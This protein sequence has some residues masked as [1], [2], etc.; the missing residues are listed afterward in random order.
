MT[1]RDALANSFNIPAVK[2]LQFAGVDATIKT[3]HDLGIKGLN[4]GSGWYGLSMTLGGGE[5]TLLDMTNAYST[6]A[7]YGNEV[8]ANPILQIADSQGQ[9]Y[10]TSIP[11]HLR[12]RWLT[13]G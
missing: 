5:V 2:A 13:Q 10:T 3:A 11:S 4:R 7:N 1:V 6:F 12:I 9:S 8:D